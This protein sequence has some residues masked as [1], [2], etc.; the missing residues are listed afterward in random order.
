MST[1]KFSPSQSIPWIKSSD[2]KITQSRL[3]LVANRRF[4]KPKTHQI[5]SHEY[6]RCVKKCNM[7]IVEWL[8]RNGRR[9]MKVIVNLIQMLWEDY[10]W[11][12]M[13]SCCLLWAPSHREGHTSCP[14]SDKNHNS[15]F[16]LKYCEQHNFRNTAAFFY[17]LQSRLG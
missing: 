7:M 2:M 4:W 1:L 5:C 17:E 11:T 3:K 8:I 9:M 15:E 10:E 6:Q 14:N 13:L 16:L 12:I